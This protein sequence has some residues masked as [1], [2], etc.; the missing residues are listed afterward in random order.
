MEKEVAPQGPRKIQD[1]IQ[2]IHYKFQALAHTKAEFFVFV[3]VFVFLF[4]SVLVFAFV[5]LFGS[6]LVFVFVAVARHV[7]TPFADLR[8]FFLPCHPPNRPLLIH[9]KE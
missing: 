4:V 5:F 1:F 3:F 2:Q 6:V 7:T 9:T 8:P